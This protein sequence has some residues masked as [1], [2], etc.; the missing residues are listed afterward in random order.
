MRQID[1]G[2]PRAHCRD[3]GSKIGTF[4][5]R[6]VDQALDIGAERLW[7]RLIL[8]Q[9]NFRS[10]VGRTPNAS[11]RSACARLAARRAFSRSKFAGASRWRASST[12]GAV[13]SPCF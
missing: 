10:I 1:L 7:Q 9:L 3:P 2:L 12:S 13:A 6:G 5:H 8:E 4:T 11:A